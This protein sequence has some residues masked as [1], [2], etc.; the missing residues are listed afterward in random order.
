MESRARQFGIIKRLGQSLCRD[1][2]LTVTL[3]L[4]ACSLQ[5]TA[6]A[7][8]AGNSKHQTPNPRPGTGAGRRGSNPLTLSRKGDIHDR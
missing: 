5:L 4:S 8:S 6:P 2:G 3:I 1:T 7:Q